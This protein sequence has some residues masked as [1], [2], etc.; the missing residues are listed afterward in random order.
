MVV[1][2]ATVSNKISRIRNEDA[3]TLSWVL[4]TRLH[5]LDVISDK[6]YGFNYLDC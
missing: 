3:A 6:A 2:I 4:S 5:F 1:K